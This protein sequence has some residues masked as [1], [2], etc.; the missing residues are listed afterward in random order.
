MRVLQTT[1]KV[2]FRNVEPVLYHVWISKE[3]VDGTWT[4]WGYTHPLKQYK[5]NYYT[6]ACTW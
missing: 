4:Y 5:V 2:E 1:W 6:V 3:E